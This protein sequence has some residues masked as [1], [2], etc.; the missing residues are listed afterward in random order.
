MAFIKSYRL[1]PFY[2]R[3]SRVRRKIKQT[4]N[5]AFRMSVFRSSSHMYVQIIDDKTGKTIAHA[6]TLNS[7][8]SNSATSDKSSSSTKATIGQ[9]AKNTTNIAIAPR[10]KNCVNIKSASALG[11]VIAERAIKAGV[12]KVVFD[13]GGYIYHG[14][15]K[16]VADAAREMGLKF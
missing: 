9:K 6:S 11:K 10:K 8:K 4:S 2:K 14:R 5:G 13:R 16:A 12:V 1:S 7:E 15:I 3:A